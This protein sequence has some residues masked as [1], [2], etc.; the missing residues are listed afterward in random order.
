MKPVSVSQEDND[1]ARLAAVVAAATAVILGVVT[2]AQLSLIARFRLLIMRYRSG[3][4]LHAQLRRVAQAVT[5]QLN[6]SL[7]GVVAEQVA[8]AVAAVEKIPATEKTVTAIHLAGDTFQSHA[9]RAVQVIRDDLAGKLN[10]LGIGIVRY[11]DDVYRAVVADAAIAELS[12]GR[13]DVYDRLIRDGIT[14]FTDSRGRRWELA[15]YVDMAVRTSMQRAFNVA[16]LAAM[17][18]AGIDLFTVSDDGHPCPL[19]LPWQG[20]ILSVLPDARADSTVTFAIGAGL[21][22][23][24]C[25]HVLVAFVEGTKRP[26]T[27]TW[28]VEDQRRYDDTQHQRA[29][30]RAIRAAK[31]EV[32]GAISPESLK[33]ATADLRRAQAQMRL[34]IERT[35]LVRRRNREQINRA[36]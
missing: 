29:L 16:H 22:H 12:G 35:G 23:P 6:E 7:T 11:A 25:R 19:C 14:G 33:H 28:T 10:Q 15:S 26:E 1:Q 31:R 20:R 30:E 24:N 2:A 13:S 32:A 5:S 21:F 8:S 36:F 34:F 4:L 17:Q 3:D 27:R 9:E 18:S